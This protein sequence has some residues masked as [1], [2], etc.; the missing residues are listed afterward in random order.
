MLMCQ[1]QEAY[2]NCPSYYSAEASVEPSKTVRTVY[3]SSCL[4]RSGEARRGGGT[5]HLAGLDHRQGKEGSGD[6]SEEA[7]AIHCHL[8]LIQPALPAAVV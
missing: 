3:L 2:R 5:R 1:A 6:A 7:N 8:V 4:H